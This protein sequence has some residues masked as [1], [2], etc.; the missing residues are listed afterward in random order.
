MREREGGREGVGGF[1]LLWLHSKRV[2]FCVPI[3]DI[4]GCVVYQLNWASFICISEV[5][6]DFFEWSD[7]CSFRG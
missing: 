5:C 3:S 4:F 1:S 2:D 7:F 6:T